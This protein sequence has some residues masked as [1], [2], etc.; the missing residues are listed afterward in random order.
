MSALGAFLTAWFKTRATFGEGTPQPGT[1]FDQS[2]KL[3]RLHSDLQRAAPAPHWSGE[4][5]TSYGNAN[6]DHQRVVGAL[7]ELDRRLANQVDQSARIVSGGRRDLDSIRDWVVAAAGRVPEGRARE[8]LLLPIVQSG[9]AQLSEV[10]TRANSDLSAVGDT[11]RT[12]DSEY[13]ALG[14]GHQFGGEPPEGPPGGAD[15]LDTDIPAE[16]DRKTNQ[17]KAF[18]EVFGR[19]P[20]DKSDW[21]TASILDPHSYNPKNQGEPPN[22]AVARIEPVPGQGVVRA[23][24]FIPSKNVWNPRPAVPP[25]DNNLGDDRGFSPAAG[26]EDARVAIYTDFDNGIVVAR[27]NPSVNSDNGEVAT[28][29]PSVS[30]V[31]QSNG[32][33]LI[34]Y[35]AADPFSFGGQELAKASGISVNGTLG[36]APSE[37]GPC[38]GGDDV[39]TFPALEVYSDR[40]GVT[41]TLLQEWPTVTADASG[42]MT[43]LI[44][45]KDVGDLSVVE[46]FNSVVP[47]LIQRV[48]T[49][50]NEPAAV[51]IT[52]P[53]PIVPPGNFTPFGPPTEAPTVRVYTPLQGYEMSPGS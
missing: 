48:P 41:S 11:I 36:I 8:H 47:E 28:G 31:Q 46:S 10:V 9:L 53:V 21:L 3:D 4:A 23:N 52:P 14:I 26:P 42:P 6:T 22:I 18:R 19:D 1:E 39:T 45:D 12:I 7:A 40:R 16:T 25:Y 13:Q 37:G 35:N 20:V 17:V 15:A 2:E 30:A 38:V 24:L 43:G 50:P 5:A 44:F 32:S 51:P 49:L 34:H 27:Q 33:V 29:V